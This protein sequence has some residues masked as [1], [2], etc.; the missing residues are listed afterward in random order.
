MFRFFGGG[1]SLIK[2]PCFHVTSADVVGKFAQFND[3][4]A[5][6]VTEMLATDMWISVGL[7][8]RII[9]GCFQKYWYPKMDGL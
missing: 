8:V 1:S 5:L 2:P 9:Y 6:W 7:K 4:M 3:S